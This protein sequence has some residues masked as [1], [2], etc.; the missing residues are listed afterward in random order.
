MSRFPPLEV[1]QGKEKH[2]QHEEKNKNE[3]ERG[4]VAPAWSEQGQDQKKLSACD[5][6]LP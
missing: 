2:D 1:L 5:A 4:G 6:L 3:V